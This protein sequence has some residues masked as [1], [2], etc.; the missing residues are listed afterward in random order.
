MA[1]QSLD[2]IPISDRKDGRGWTFRYRANDGSRPRVTRP[3]LLEALVA[4]LELELD[5]VIQPLEEIGDV[6]DSD[7]LTLRQ[8]FEEVYRVKHMPELT[9]ACAQQYAKYFSDHVDPVLGDMPI[10]EIGRSA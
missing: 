3:T 5:Y 4:W 1:I 8:F 10:D 2:Q 7:C 6:P 9:S